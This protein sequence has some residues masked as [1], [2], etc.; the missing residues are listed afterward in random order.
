I[1]P[2]SPLPS[3][4]PSQ[5]SHP[6]SPIPLSPRI[7]LEERALD[8]YYNILFSILEFWRRN[9]QTAASW[10]ERLT[11]V[12]HA[13]K[14]AR[15][16]DSHCA[17]IGFPLDRVAF[18]GINP[19]NLPAALLAADKASQELAA[20]GGLAP[21]EVS[22]EKAEAMKGVRETVGLWSDDPHGVGK[23][24]VGKRRTRNPWGVSQTLFLHDEERARSGAETRTVG[25]TEALV[26]GGT[27]PWEKT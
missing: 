19:P 11:I 27:R 24:L 12:S 10:P 9:G 20:A 22:E 7:M 3:H 2:A 5:P 6:L 16:V 13:F 4:H 25:G 23:V 21:G 1:P 14:R 17:A 18:I 8:S 26:E 15:L